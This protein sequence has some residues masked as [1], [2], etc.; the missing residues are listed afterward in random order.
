VNISD[1]IGYTVVS[2]LMKITV[3]AG[4]E[5]LKQIIPLYKVKERLLPSQV[6]EI[7]MDT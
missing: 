2:K 3:A 1:P 7:V 4:E 5:N 6:H